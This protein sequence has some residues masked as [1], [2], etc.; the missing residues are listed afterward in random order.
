MSVLLYIIDR[1]LNEGYDYKINAVCDVQNII[2]ALKERTA[3]EVVFTLQ[4]FFEEKIKDLQEKI[5]KGVENED[6]IGYV[7]FSNQ[8]EL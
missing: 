5:N 6:I 4:S 8:R 3:E 2:D 1:A 7:R